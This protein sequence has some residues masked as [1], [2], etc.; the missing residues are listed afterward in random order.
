M[1]VGRIRGALSMLSA[2]SRLM[3]DCLPSM[4]GHGAAVCLGYM[5]DH[6]KQNE[7]KN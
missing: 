3:T 1:S 2:T 6:V 5:R 4:T 7:T